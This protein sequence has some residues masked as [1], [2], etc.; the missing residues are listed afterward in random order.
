MG[1][2]SLNEEVDTSDKITN[3]REKFENKGDG[4]GQL[5]L[6]GYSYGS[7]VAAHVAM[8]RVQ[9]GGT[10]DNLVL[11]GAPISKEF[12][13]T[14]RNTEGIRNI[15]VKNLTQHGDPIFAGM[16]GTQV[17]K[18]S[19]T[20][21]S[22]MASGAGVGHFYYASNNVTGRVRRRVLAWELYNDG[23]R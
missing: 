22:Q 18:S 19:F 2:L 11:I 5:N 15:I 20:L 12:L 21:A 17:A 16:S 1:V 3:M 9:K 14:L 6:V 10:V 7:L 23:L 8:T 4:K 13:N